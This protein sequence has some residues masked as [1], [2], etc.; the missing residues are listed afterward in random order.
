MVLQST[1]VMNTMLVRSY[2]GLAAERLRRPR[3]W[4]LPRTGSYD[5]PGPSPTDPRW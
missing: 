3:Y 1:R 5:C 4:G 2:L